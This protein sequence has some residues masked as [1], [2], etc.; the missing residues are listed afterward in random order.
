[1]IQLRALGPVDI[2]IDGRAAPPELLWRKN[3]ALL[4][5]LARSPRRTRSREHLMGL[6]WGDK[7][8]TSARH[9][10][11]EAMRVL[12]AAGG[13]R[14]LETEGDQIQ[15]AADAVDLDVDHFT[16]LADAGEWAA[17][18]RLAIGAFL[19]GF[20]VPDAPDFEDWLRAER[21]GLRRRST[22]VLLRYAEQRQRA[23]QLG[24]AAECA[25]RALAFDPDSSGAVQA[26][27]RAHALAGE[28]AAAL[29]AFER[30]KAHLAREIGVDPDDAASRLADQIRKG[31]AKEPA[32]AAPSRGAESRRAPLVGR[33]RE[34]EQLIETWQHACS[35]ACAF[36][37]LEGPAGAGR[38]RLTEEIGE[39][40]RLDGAA[41]IRVRGVP[42]DRESPWSGIHGLATGGLLDASG[43]G[44][45]SGA[46]L[47]R[48]A[49][50]SDAWA[51]R[52]PAARRVAQPLEPGL[53]F[54]AVLRAA[55][56]DQRLVIVMDDAHWLDGE[57]LSLLLTL[58]R[59]LE[60]LPVL[61]VVSAH[62][63]PP[64]EPI[65]MLGS[66]VGR[67]MPGVR[68]AIEPLASDAIR[69]LAAWAMPG[70]TPTDI[71]RLARRVAADSAGLPLIAV[72]LLHAVALGLDVH[73][74]E[75][76][77]PD[78]HRTLDQTLPGT[79]PDT[80]VAAVRIGFRR[81][82]RDAQQCVAATAVLGERADQ[83]RL[84]A[85]TGLAADDLLRAL[86]EAE[87]ERWIVADGR[88]Y[89]FVARL[90][91][92]IVARDLVT[93]GQRR[94]ILSIA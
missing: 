48:F 30:W 44:G 87:W 88:G 69:A 94:R 80:V 73:G 14:L 56:M 58:A 27:M 74:T 82:G 49:Q 59:D 9:S 60:G 68:L 52:F 62:A 47:A 35:G 71:D 72:E 93:S 18:S 79:L 63:Q 3:L 17:A 65:E 32:R 84:A 24:A 51:D 8:D 33:D 29:A 53:A 92:D 81:L 90:A 77:W 19:E 2:T 57:T 43:I 38:T 83:A 86:D 39:R 76:A 64:R 91:R 89:G 5:Y 42:A 11:R 67:D 61:F 46:A 21:S 75:R 20:G 34:L 4:V 36:A 37:V 1:M 85:A 28:R 6:L 13:E 70:W 54:A 41:V 50:R 10:L 15:L 16:T 22:D 31:R 12:R 55:A 7:P 78:P 23:G 45:A 26:L 25:A 40:A 66:R